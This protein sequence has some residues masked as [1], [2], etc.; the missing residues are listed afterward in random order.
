MVYGTLF[1][2]PQ[3]EKR[4]LDRTEGLG[5]GYFEQSVQ[6]VLPNGRQMIAKTYLADATHIEENLRP[7]FWYK[8][9][10]VSGA[11]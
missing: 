11:E 4:N 10:V 1:K 7:Y 2:I 6:I 9:F 8:E 3:E 5:L